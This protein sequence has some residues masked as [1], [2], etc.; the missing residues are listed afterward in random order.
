MNL[1]YLHAFYVTVKANSISKAAK[2]LH[3]TQPGLSMQIQALEK[4]L[5]VDLLKRSNRGVALTEGGKIVF[6]YADTILSL[7]DN[8]ERDLKSLKSDRKQLLIG[9]CKTVGEYALPCSIYIYKHENK[10]VDVNLEI[11]NTDT[12][13]KKLM[14]RSINIGIIQD[15]VKEPGLKL[16]KITSDKLLLVTAIPIIKDSVCL[17]ELKKLPLVLR[18]KGSGCRRAI[19]SHLKARKVEIEELNV[20]YE[21][22]SMEAIK[23]SVVSGKGFAFLSQL[24]IKRELRDGALRKVDI[25]DLSIVSD[26][27]I[28]Y[29]E[30][31]TLLPH[32]EDFVRFLRSNKRGFC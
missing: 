19:E 27:H 25:Q 29:R 7:Q 30:E 8:I 1:Q 12:V 20:L 22:N 32:E 23:S 14:D 17:E 16:L 21:L 11:S 13:V 3:L 10:N 6:D 28:A 5:Q 24:S 9:S 31:Y 2:L 15:K 4:E 18:E 26:F